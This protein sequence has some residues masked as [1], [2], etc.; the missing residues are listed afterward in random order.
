MVEYYVCMYENGSMR[1][2]ETVLGMGEEGIK[3]IDGR[4]EFNHD[5]L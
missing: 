5:I 2:V 3:E 1:P 4:G